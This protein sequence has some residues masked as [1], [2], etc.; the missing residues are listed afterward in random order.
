M[1]WIKRFLGI[2]EKATYSSADDLIK[3]YGHEEREIRNAASFNGK[4]YT[5]HIEYVKQLKHERKH[6]EA[7]KLL[8]RA[9]LRR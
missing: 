3:A 2:E 8:L 9:N 4:H 5:E 7:I 6:N 1:K